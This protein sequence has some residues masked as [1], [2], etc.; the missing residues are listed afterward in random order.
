MLVSDRD[1]GRC[2]SDKMVSKGSGSLCG[3]VTQEGGEAAASHGISVMPSPSPQHI[4]CS[5]QFSRAC[6]DAADTPTT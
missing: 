3:P 5:V 4:L 2:G 6:A 1:A